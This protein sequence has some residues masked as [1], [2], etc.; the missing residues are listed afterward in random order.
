M[1]RAKPSSCHWAT[2]QKD[3]LKAD[4]V[5]DDMIPEIVAYFR[6]TLG[7]TDTRSMK[8][9]AEFGSKA[10]KAIPE[11]ERIRDEQPHRAVEAIRTIKRIKGK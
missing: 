11:L 8:F 10:S 3:Y 7:E 5:P 1:L 4:E 9:L 2:F 6:F